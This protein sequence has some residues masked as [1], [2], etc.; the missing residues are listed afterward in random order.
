M[1]MLLAKMNGL[2]EEL[3]YLF[4]QHLYHAE[5][6]KIEM[7]LGNPK[8]TLFPVLYLYQGHTLN[9]EKLAF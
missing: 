7:R 1:V 3:Q 2:L 9:I 6:P 4:T 5:S 8:T